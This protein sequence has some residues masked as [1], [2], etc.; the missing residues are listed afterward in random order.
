MNKKPS[1]HLMAQFL[2]RK[3]EY[4]DESILLRELSEKPLSEALV[5][6]M[7]TRG[8]D[9]LEAAQLRKRQ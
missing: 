8:L 9:K 3:L 6:D 1:S 5:E 4:D 2:N 7:F